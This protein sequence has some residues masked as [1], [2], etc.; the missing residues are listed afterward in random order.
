LRRLFFF[1]PACSCQLLSKSSRQLP[2]LPVFA[3]FAS[4]PNHIPDRRYVQS[5][6]HFEVAYTHLETEPCETFWRSLSL[7]GF[8]TNVTA[9]AMTRSRHIAFGQSFGSSKVTYHDLAVL[10]YLRFQRRCAKRN[11]GHR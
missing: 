7:M 11:F 5:S 10:I 1:W 6:L 4:N 3:I 8:K 2:N 9:K